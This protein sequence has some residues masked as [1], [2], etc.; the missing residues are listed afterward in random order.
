MSAQTPP[1]PDLQP[2][3]LALADSDPRTLADALRRIDAELGPHAAGVAAVGLIGES[4]R[5]D[6]PSLG[7]LEN[8][9]RQQVRAARERAAELHRRA[10]GG[11]TDPTLRQQA[12]ELA[13]EL[14]KL[15]DAEADIAFEG[16]NTDLGAGE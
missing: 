6:R 16:K 11:A 4:I 8:R 14:R 12:A 13:A 1:I 3:E 5:V 9:L 10:T 2:L 15:R 7:R